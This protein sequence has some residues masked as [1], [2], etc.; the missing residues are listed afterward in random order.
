MGVNSPGNNPPT[1]GDPQR[2]SPR[3]RHCLNKLTPTDTLMNHTNIK[4]S[5]AS[6]IQHAKNLAYLGHPYVLSE[7]NSIANQGIDGET[8]V[9]GD[10]LWL[11]DLSLWAGA[12][13]RTSPPS[14]F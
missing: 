5:L 11:V 10:A 4:Q 3:N 8:N 14:I 13:V 12:H 1:A 6:H 7:L 2:L 9:F